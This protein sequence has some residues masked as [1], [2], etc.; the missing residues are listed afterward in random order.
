VPLAPTTGT[1]PMTASAKNAHGR[2]GGRR[3][4]IA[5]DGEERGVYAAG[6]DRASAPRTAPG[7]SRTKNALGVDAQDG[8]GGVSD[9]TSLP[10]RGIRGGCAAQEDRVCLQRAF[11]TRL[12]AMI[13]F[14]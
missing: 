7:P 6:E 13:S 8:G 9:P 11:V 5:E 1:P 14:S 4:R 12:I 2:C 10:P 3:G